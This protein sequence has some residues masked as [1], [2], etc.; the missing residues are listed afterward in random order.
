MQISAHFD[1]VSKLNKTRHFPLNY[2]ERCIAKETY[3]QFT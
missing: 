2:C 1:L 3:F